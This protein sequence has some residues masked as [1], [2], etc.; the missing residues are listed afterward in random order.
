[1]SVDDD[2]DNEPLLDVQRVDL[3]TF[4]A[5][6]TASPHLAPTD[7]WPS[8]A[9]LEPADE[10]Q[11][12]AARRVLFG[13]TRAH[14]ATRSECARR[15]ATDDAAEVL[16]VWA[17]LDRNDAAAIARFVAAN[18][19]PS[20]ADVAA[21][22]ARD[23]VA[24]R[25]AVLA[26]LQLELRLESDLLLE[27]RTL[28]DVSVMYAV[29]CG[30]FSCID[31]LLDAGAGFTPG[32]LHSELMP[33]VRAC[34][35]AQVLR[36]LVNS[37]VDLLRLEAAFLATRQFGGSDC[38]FPFRV[39]R[40][41]LEDAFVF[42]QSYRRNQLFFTLERVCA[43]AAAAVPAAD[44]DAA[45]VAF[46]RCL[47]HLP[48]LCRARIVQY[49][50]SVPPPERDTRRLVVARAARGQTWQRA[51]V[52]DERPEERGGNELCVKFDNWGA[53]F[54][55][56]IPAHSER[57]EPW[58]HPRWRAVA[59]SARFEPDRAMIQAWLRRQ[60]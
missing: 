5:A 18:R 51:T 54:N 37:N 15:V 32:T 16:D 33:C 22:V 43:A 40:S 20:S 46:V 23:A 38:P 28:D 44:A 52:V 2:D 50:V 10:A 3:F 11:L 35:R 19:I 55:E 34:S 36:M 29:R 21:A 53:L 8:P 27:L 39:L 6:S 1:M 48:R 56:W 14:S 7:P 24:R 47:R 4:D 26:Q 25:S 13:A 45:I 9:E 12:A 31:A 49:A 59:A 42:D 57:L 41:L 17:A 60:E 30:A 58:V